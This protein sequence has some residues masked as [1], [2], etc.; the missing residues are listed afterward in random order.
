MS[1]SR[2]PETP[3]QFT[4]V[5]KRVPEEYLALLSGTRS[6]QGEN[7]HLRDVWFQKLQVE[8]KSERLFEFETLLKGFACFANPRNHP[9]A[10][11]V[12]HVS[13]AA[14]DF[15]PH[16][17]LAQGALHRATILAKQLAVQNEP[18]LLFR[19]YL[20]TSLPDDSARVT[21]AKPDRETPDGA[22]LALRRGLTHAEEIARSLSTLYRLPFRSFYALMGTVQREAEDSRFFNALSALEFRIE[23][24]RIASPHVL[25]AMDA[26]RGAEARKLCALTF[27]SLYR[28]LRYMTLVEANLAEVIRDSKQ[29]AQA[30][31]STH[32]IWTV[33]RS[34]ARALIARIG[35]HAGELLAADFARLLQT[36]SAH[37]VSPRFAELLSE[38]HVHQ[39]LKTSLEGMAASLNL[40]TRQTF[41]HDLPRPDQELSAAEFA[42]RNSRAIASLKP[43]IQNAILALGASLG[44]RLDDQG[45]FGSLAERRVMSERLRRDLWMFAQILRAFSEKASQSHTVQE[46]WLEPSPFAFVGQFLTYFKA[47]GYPLIRAADYARLDPFLSAVDAVKGHHYVDPE[48]LT[49][50]T[51]EA[52]L[53]RQYLL[54]LF[55]Q[56]SQ[57]AELTETPFERKAAATSLAQYLGA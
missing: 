45:V 51:E 18:S 5:Q 19:R 2:G 50:A 33:F 25:S 14:Q 10:S 54:E 30:I 8:R 46:Q 27:L 34:D 15:A 28:L 26:V 44:V 49:A 39:D 11:K 48:R 57:R 35:K 41:E 56:V 38:A 31:G 53:F 17:A 47:M 32:L 55:D 43:V 16:I 22:L 40:E 4:R 7:A 29:A 21:L 1:E 6:L 20:E 24:D 42:L 9:G 13:L 36:V 37:D 12:R 23:Y 3:K 52:M